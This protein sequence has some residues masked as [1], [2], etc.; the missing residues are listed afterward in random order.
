M[1]VLTPAAPMTVQR[2]SGASALASPKLRRAK[3]KVKRNG[4][5]DFDSDIGTWKVQMKRLL[6]PLTGSHTWVEY[7]GTDVIRKVWGG[8]A[9][10]GEVEV[11]GPAGH[12]E[13]LNLRLYNP[14]ADQ[15]SLNIA[16]SASGTLSPP[17]VGEFKNGRGEF[18][19]QEPYNG[20]SILVR[21]DVSDITPNLWRF[22][23]AFSDDG[24]K[25]WETNL[26]VTETRVTDAPE[27]WGWMPPAAQ[28]GSDVRQQGEQHD[29]DFD[30][31][32]WK[33]QIR[34]A[35]NALSKS[36]A[37]AELN[38]TDAV[39][40]IWGGRA[41]LAE[42]EAGGPSG[43]IEFLSLRLYNPQSRQWSLNVATSNSG[44]VNTPSVGSFKDGRGEFYDQETFNERAV[45]GRTVWSDITPS[46]YNFEES[47]SDDGGRTWAPSFIAKLTREKS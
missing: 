31:G 4:Q 22:E 44:T 10:L 2:S 17:A 30:F 1:L 34:H 8:R 29:F 12:F 36:P 21:F 41:N 15:W 37:W 9:N 5:H 42:V 40:K 11:E 43:H 24:G 3:P 25:S 27:P 13:L 16:S 18:Y 45:L 26:K 32:T 28:K 38:G 19:D 14:E 47:F 39:H 20:R 23:Q 7:N 35:H 33:V 46:S 6:H